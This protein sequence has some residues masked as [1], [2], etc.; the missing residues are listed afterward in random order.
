[1][2]VVSLHT[3][4]L[5]GG[6][7]VELHAIFNI[8][9]RLRLLEVRFTPQAFYLWRKCPPPHLTQFPL[10]EWA[11]EPVHMFERRKKISHPF[12]IVQ[13]ISRSLAI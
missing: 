5:Y 2:K 7:E 3:M 8:S 1:M 9:P 12:K 6:V 4:N 11:P 10:R 13:P